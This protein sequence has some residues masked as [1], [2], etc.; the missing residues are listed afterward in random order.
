MNTKPANPPTTLIDPF[1]VDF[2]LDNGVMHGASNVL[3]RKTSDMRGYYAD[4]QALEELIQRDGDSIHYKVYEVPVPQEYGH[5]MYCISDLQPGRVGDEC[6]MTKGHYHSV[7]ETGEI[8]MCLAGE[9][10]MMMKTTDGRCK[11]ESFS[12]G[13]MVYV[14]PYWAHR[15]INTGSERLITFCVYPGDAGH[16]YGDIQSEGFPK[17]VFH[18]AGTIVVE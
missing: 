14:P 10:I 2:D 6:F 16:N 8:Y 17:R 1:H 5:L 11:S 13:R 3:Q 9:G 12:R 15:S 18:R 4:E 7:L